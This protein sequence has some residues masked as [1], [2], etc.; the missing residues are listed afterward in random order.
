MFYYCGF[1]NCWGSWSQLVAEDS[2]CFIVSLVL[3]HFFSFF[4]CLEKLWPCLVYLLFFIGLYQ[5]WLD[6][7]SLLTFKT[8]DTQTLVYHNFNILRSKFFSSLVTY[9]SPWKKDARASLSYLKLWSD[10]ASFN[11]YWYILLIYLK[12]N[13]I[14]KSRLVHILF[15]LKH[16]KLK[17]EKKFLS[18]WNIFHARTRFVNSFIWYSMRNQNSFKLT[19]FLF[20][21]LLMLVKMSNQSFV[22]TGPKNLLQGTSETFCLSVEDSIYAVANCTLELLSSEE[23][24]VYATSNHRFNG[25]FIPRIFYFF[26]NWTVAKSKFFTFRKWMILQV[27]IK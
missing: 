20:A 10:H 7:V 8:S 17:N 6:P 27:L 25:I 3:A 23:N 15:K 16:A 18:N 14:Y 19:S 11:T 4:L 22:L 1:L 5:L 26:L 24:I 21:M 13:M 12:L 2:S 9:S